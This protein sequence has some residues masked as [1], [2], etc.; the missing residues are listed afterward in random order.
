M[1]PVLVYPDHLLHLL[2]IAGQADERTLLRTATESIATLL[3]ERGSCILTD[4]IPRVTFSTEAP[5]LLDWPIDLARYPE[6]TASLQLQ[7]VMAIEDVQEDPLLARVKM[8]LP[9]DLRSIV[10][11]P[12]TAGNHQLGVLIAR[13]SVQRRP[14]SAE[15]ATAMLIGRMAAQLLEGLRLRAAGADSARL[16]ADERHLKPGR[17]GRPVEEKTDV[18]NRAGRQ[19]RILVVDDDD[20]IC[21][22]LVQ[23]LSAEGY[24]VEPAPNGATAIDSAR[25]RPPDLIVLDVGMPELDG[26]A[27]AAKLRGDPVTSQVPILF[28]SA[29]NELMARVRGLKLGQLDFLSKP[30]LAGELLARIDQSMHHLTDRERLRND[31]FVDELTGLGNLR[32]LQERIAME[33]ARGERHGTSVAMIIIDVDGLKTINDTHGHATGSAVLA[34][35]GRI[36]H[37]GA[38]ETDV[39]VRYGGDEFVILLP[40]AT[41]DDGMNC[42]N[43]ILTQVRQIRPVG[44]S[45][46]VSIGVWAAVASSD[47]SLWSLFE[48]ADT[49]AFAAKRLGGDRACMYQPSGMVVGAVGASG[50]AEPHLTTRARRPAA[51]GRLSYGS[52]GS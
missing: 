33:Q 5:L 24:A 28:L 38:R 23:A 41:V 22:S 18:T 19:R 4:G 52:S 34:A 20:D 31:A 3:G 16:A 7:T 45:A 50:C 42:A 37:E 36:V 25:D 14:G 49:A 44:V 51:N 10:V 15:V 32:L 21:A 29:S 47:C 2:A 35:I 8:L 9:S 30:F 48:H 12:L 17:T 11:V 43:R 6:I 46:T 1:E 26:F 13:S 39:A 40:H 27:V